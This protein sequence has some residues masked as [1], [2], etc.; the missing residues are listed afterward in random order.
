MIKFLK[1]IFKKKE[2][3]RYVHVEG[4]CDRDSV[5]SKAEGYCNRTDYSPV[6]AT[7][8]YNRQLNQR[9]GE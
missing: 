5:C 8:C 6:V 9:F 3:V 1:K 7:G 4:Y 2:P